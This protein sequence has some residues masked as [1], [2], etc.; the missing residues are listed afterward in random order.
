MRSMK[1]SIVCFKIVWN[2]DYKI[3]VFKNKPN[4][5]FSFFH[6]FKALKKLCFNNFNFLDFFGLF[7]V[8]KTIQFS[9]TLKPHNILKPLALIHP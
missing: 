4:N 8:A 2:D 7:L 6:R 1:F 5:F 3:W 9:V